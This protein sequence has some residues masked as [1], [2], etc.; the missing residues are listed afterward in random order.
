MANLNHSSWPQRQASIV[1]GISL[2]LMAVLAGFGNFGA[3]VPLI[4]AGG[5]EATAQTLRPPR[6]CSAPGWPA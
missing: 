1:A 6:C 3:L 4:V 2:L 5:S